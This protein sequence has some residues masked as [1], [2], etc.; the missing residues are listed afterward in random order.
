MALLISIPVCL[1][2]Q[3]NPVT[4][5]IKSKTQTKQLK[6]GDKFGVQ[7][8]AQI[9][10]GWH[11]YST[12]Q[13][14][15]GPVATRITLPAGQP[16]KL[17]GAIESA[18][19]LTELDPNFGIDTRFYEDSAVFT[20]PIAVSTSAAP[21]EGKQR[22]QVN[23]FFQ[24]CNDK[25][26]LPP[27]TIKLFSNLDLAANAPGQ[28]Q[29]ETTDATNTPLA[30]QSPQAT[31]APEPDPNSSTGQAQ[32]SSS[33]AAV[34]VAS[35]TP[36]HFG[37]DS[38][39][40]L[41][42]FIWLA[43]SLGALSLLT[44]CVFPMIPITVSYFTNHTTGNHSAA[45]RDAFIYALGIVLTFTV[46]GVLLAMLFGA[47]G[48]NKFAASPWINLLITAI[49]IGFAISLF[50]GYNLAIPSSVLTKLDALSRGKEST[51]FLGPLLMGL[52]FSLTSFTCTAPFVGTLL[53]MAAQGKWLYPIVGMLAFSSVF[54]LPFFVL[55]LVPQLI[56]QL[57]K[58]G[59]WL[60]S[61]KVVMG[62]LEIAAA[63]KF[64]SNVDLI[65][66]WGV[67]TREVVLASWVAVATLI[68]VYLLGNFR[69]SHD[70][71]GERIGA[72]RLMIAL[73][74]L[75][76]GLYL[77][78][79]L[80]GAR[81]GELE[82][83]LPPTIENSS[84]AGSAI[85]GSGRPQAHELSW[86]TNDYESGL[87]Q[88]RGENK[89][90]F[91]DFTGY[92]CTNCR[93]MEVNMFTKVSVEEELVKYV[94]VR[95]YTDGEGQPYEGFQRMQQEK[96]GTVALPLYA[97]VNGDGNTITTFSGLT[98]N[99]AEFV[100]FLKIGQ[101]KFGSGPR[102]LNSEARHSFSESGTK[103]SSSAFIDR[104]LC[105][106]LFVEECAERIRT[107]D[108]LTEMDF[109][110]TKLPST[111]KSHYHRQTALFRA[112]SERE[113]IAQRAC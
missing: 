111:S 66:H 13:Q 3:S 110:S 72:L 94:R 36:V 64:L 103:K 102:G 34:T 8:I 101:A 70:S 96:F 93:W 57:P 41:I 100:S 76:L 61:V 22:L 55:A 73:M 74:M 112:N 51:R 78:T 65:W 54:A 69:L 56:S 77:V 104:D 25:F 50:G 82:S 108:G 71:P 60:N 68:T 107:R 21:I 35:P 30:N 52:T 2:A 79:G 45:A 90:L 23:V 14:A 20:L 49:F 27:R 53:V 43:M 5:A 89:P 46:L 39:R 84:S 19:P 106:T 44:P 16:F 80:F 59:G 85:R 11:L 62:L 40:S 97:V 88:A 113:R 105:R 18:A 6:P 4:F 10:E 38:N 83:F 42:S 9:K 67:F 58:A 17:A 24:T 87:R 31:G 86:I 95:L 63:M 29:A 92:T 91:I 28:T 12:T 81:L 48:I 7:V 37:V 75:S 26:C 98:R 99:Q 47:A 15:G 109:C 32:T 33:S 1:A